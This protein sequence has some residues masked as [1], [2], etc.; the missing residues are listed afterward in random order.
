MRLI[1]VKSTGSFEL[2]DGRY[3]RIWNAVDR[4]GQR[5]RMVVVSISMK[6]GADMKE[7]QRTLRD[8]PMS[9]LEMT[10]VC[11]KKDIS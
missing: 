4:K 11:T 5:V 3:C 6:N 2:V 7:V 10:R 9:G 1:E 8:V